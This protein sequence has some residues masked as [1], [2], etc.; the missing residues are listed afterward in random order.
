M[1]SRIW[2]LADLALIV[3]ERELELTFGFCFKISCDLKT[4]KAVIAVMQLM[5]WFSG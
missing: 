4:I 1:G 5:F 2:Q 3:R